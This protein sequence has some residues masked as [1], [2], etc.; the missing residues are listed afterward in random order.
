MNFKRRIIEQRI[1][2]PLANISFAV[3]NSQVRAIEKSGIRMMH[4]ARPFW[5]YRRVF[6]QGQCAKTVLN[7]LKGKVVVDVGCG[8]T[9]FADD[10][11]F[12]ACHKAGIEFYGIDPLLAK[13]VNIR[14]K[15]RMLARAMGSSGNF[16]HTPQNQSKAIS[17]YADKLPFADQSVDQ[18]LT[19]FLLFVWIKDEAALAK[20]FREFLRVLKPGGIA[21][22]YPLPEWRL[23]NFKS[24]ELIEVLEQFAIKQAFVHGGLD[25]RVTPA[26]LTEMSK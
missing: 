9:P 18:I 14:F 3:M 6:F 2:R 10:S 20:I 24:I 5:Y 21:K 1:T 22:L 17:A 7:E 19:S 16:D 8:Y 26:M 25:F 15:D 23:M 11:M 13:Q 12:Q 4:T